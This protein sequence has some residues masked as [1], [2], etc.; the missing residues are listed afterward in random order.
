MSETRHKNPKKETPKKWSSAKDPRAEKK[1]GKYPNQIITKTRSG[2]IPL[3]VDDTPEHESMTIQHR[4]GSAFQFLPDGSVQITS[5]HGKYDIVFG[6]NRM[7]VTGAHDLTVK[8]HG[9]MMVY[10]DYNKA[11]HG[12][13][14]MTVT[15]SYNMTAD[16]HNAVIRNNMDVAVGGNKTTKIAGSESRQIKKSFALASGEDATVASSGGTLNFGAKGQVSVATN[17]QLSFFADSFGAKIKNDYNLVM[18]GDS[19]MNIV[20]S[21]L[22]DFG[23]SSYDTVGGDRHSKGSGTLYTQYSTQRHQETAQAA[24]QADD[25]NN[26]NAGKS[27]S[28][29]K[30][31]DTSGLTLKDKS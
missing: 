4:S 20:V 17:D 5:P 12:D 15:G 2:N 7:T 27:D 24:Q 19:K 1:A 18:V 3:M 22:S 28:P 26:P 8:G 31:S 30:L 6:E 9:S 29:A 16:S 10:G 25:P 11:I 14:N 13:V 23:Q 21:H